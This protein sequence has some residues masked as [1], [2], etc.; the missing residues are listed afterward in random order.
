MDTSN[1][2]GWW[3]CSE[4]DAEAEL[5]GPD[6]VGFEVRCPDCTGSMNEQWRWD[7]AA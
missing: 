3:T 5:P 7:A 2:M 6:T 4:C 1:T